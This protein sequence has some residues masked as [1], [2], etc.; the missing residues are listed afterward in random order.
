[1]KAP[2]NIH[3]VQEMG[4]VRDSKGGV[5]HFSSHELWIVLLVLGRNIIIDLH[6]VLLV[7]LV[8]VQVVQLEL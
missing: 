8:A 6:Y 5:N 4:V 7:V 3:V 2:A 1:M